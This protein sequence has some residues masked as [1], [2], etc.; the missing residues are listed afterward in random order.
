[1]DGRTDGEGA[2][3][4]AAPSMI[5]GSAIFAAGSYQECITICAL[6]RV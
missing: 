3:V 2:T 1:M 5:T 4:N 6:C